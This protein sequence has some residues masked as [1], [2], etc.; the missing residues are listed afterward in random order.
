MVN[1]ELESDGPGLG[2]K[3]S[4]IDRGCPSTKAECLEKSENACIG[5]GGLEGPAMDLDGARKGDGFGVQNNPELAFDNLEV[6][7]DSSDR[8]CPPLGRLI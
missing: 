8:Q 3:A 2:M 5:G 4:S 1:E 7:V 6:D